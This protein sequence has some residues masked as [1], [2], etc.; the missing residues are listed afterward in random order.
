MIEPVSLDG[1]VVEPGTVASL[2]FI[3]AYHTELGS[4]TAGHMVAALFEFDHG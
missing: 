2:P 4:A 1:F 3:P